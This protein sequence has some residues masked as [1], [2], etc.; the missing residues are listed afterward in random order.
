MRLLHE[1]ELSCLLFLKERAGQVIEL[2]GS[3][4]EYSNYSNPYHTH[5]LLKQ[6]NKEKVITI[7]GAYIDYSGYFADSFL[8]EV[9][10]ISP[11]KY[12]KM[13]CSLAPRPG[14]SPSKF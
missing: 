12:G 10:G 4:V 5:L 8:R 11:I 7:E 14:C 13:W 1:D 9:M 2:K 3:D 6:L